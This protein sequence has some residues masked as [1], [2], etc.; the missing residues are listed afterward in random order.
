MISC[1]HSY[2]YELLRS[3]EL[4]SFL[5]GASR[6]I[7]VESI[8]AYIARRKAANDGKFRHGRLPPKEAARRARGRRA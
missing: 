3:G 6:K 1:G 2:G 8:K 4:E 5:D 7:I